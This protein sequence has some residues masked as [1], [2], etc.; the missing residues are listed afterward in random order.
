MLRLWIRLY[1]GCDRPAE[2]RIAEEVQRYTLR[3]L[4]APPA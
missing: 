3:R 4:S 1:S 2:A